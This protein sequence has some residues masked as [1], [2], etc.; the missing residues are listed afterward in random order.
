MIT[1]ARKGIINTIMKS[2]EYAA[3]QCES[4]QARCDELLCTSV[5]NGTIEN[6]E[7][8]DWII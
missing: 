4:C 1:F 8:T 7:Y 3:P 6:V 5:E 2:I